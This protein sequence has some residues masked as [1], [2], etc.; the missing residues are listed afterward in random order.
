MHTPLDD[1][2]AFIPEGGGVHRVR[3]E[4]GEV[5]PDDQIVAGA[6]LAGAVVV[7]ILAI[8][9]VHLPVLLGVAAL[10]FAAAAVALQ[11]R[12]V[13]RDGLVVP[14]PAVLCLALAAYTLLQILPLPIRW[15]EV[16]APMAA[17]IWHRSLLP[18]GE[19]GPRWASLSLDPGASAVEALKWAV[20]GA[21]FVAAATVSS[22]HGASWGL[23]IVFGAAVL[24]ALVTLG[25]GLTEA[26]RVYGLYQP[27]SQVS[28]WHVG[29]LLN[30]NNLAGYLN[31]GAILG[32]GLMLADRPRFPRWLLGLGVVLVVGI[33][34]TAASR[35]G[36]ASLLV[37]VA[38]L[39][40]FT[41]RRAEE[42]PGMR[43]MSSWMLLGVVAAGGVL[44]V[45]GS[46]QKTWEELYDKD[47]SKLSMFLWAKPM[48][49]DHA[50]FGVGRGA[51][52]SAFPVYRTMPGNVVFTHPE[53][54]VVQW[55][56]EWG[57]PVTLAA[58]ATCAWAFS[59]SRL[60]ALR[61]TV[62]ASAWCGVGILLL[63]NM[64][65]LGL[66]IPAVSVAAATTLG[67]LWGDRHRA[68]T[69]EALRRPGPLAL[70][71]VQRVT[72]GIGA[73]GAALSILALTLGLHDI[74]ADRRA[75]HEAV[76]R[77]G[78]HAQAPGA[79]RQLL[80]QAMLRHP[81][82]PY[83][84]LVG[85]MLALQSHSAEGPIPWLQRSLERAQLN[86]RA[87][88]LLAE[89]LAARGTR[90][91]ALFEL[92]LA[93]TDDPAVVNTAGALAMHWTQS[94][95]EISAAVPE[96]KLGARLLNAVAV[97]ARNEN[98]S[99][100]PA[101]IALARRCER[102]AIGRDPDYAEPRFS[103]ASE[104]V[105]A[106]AAQARS[107][108]AGP[109]LRRPRRLPGPDRRGHRG[110]RPDPPRLVDGPHAPRPPA[111]RRRQ[112]R[113]GGQAPRRDLRAVP[114]A[115]ELHD[116]PRDRR[117]PDQ[118]AG[119]GRRRVQGAARHRLHAFLAA[120]R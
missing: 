112:A 102:E 39:A 32:L 59:P 28:A 88:L 41:R 10:S 29:P 20:Y 83:F 48:L 79:A 2:D 77:A 63:Q 49:R 43:S 86:G 58:L 71:S 120:V 9:A 51:F 118:G 11:R 109:A 65:D 27:E 108:R 35:A 1:D 21:V 34:L 60:G 81:A 95:D 115:H 6:L 25:H 94:Y 19:Q 4:R 7:S 62:A 46:T 114:R 72:L 38:A 45:L 78:G 97:V 47:L 104:L 101:S 66:E 13:G 50:L 12:A 92:R 53:N 23:H 105:D 106:L 44:A 26:S 90:L 37:G 80:R 42:R 14:L 91:Q 76:D 93:V 18:F 110:P 70:P 52:E 64:L 100:R 117:R 67:S 55:A 40:L 107:A 3:R 85:A 113:R 89:V 54:F 33:G 84:P 57:V 96:G 68:R 15:L 17:D 16:L 99:P 74:D 111:P 75:V 22:R 82:E 24:A 119:R 8:G 31:L 69:R 61:S 56:A 5:R 87:H 36:V 103:E 116:G 98:P 73:A 30:P